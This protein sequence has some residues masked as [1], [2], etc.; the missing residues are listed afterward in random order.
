MATL[1]PLWTRAFTLHSDLDFDGRIAIAKDD[2]SHTIAPH[3]LIRGLTW[4]NETVLSVWPGGIP[5]TTSNDSQQQWDMPNAWPPLQWIAMEAFGTVSA[6]V[7]HSNTSSM[8]LWVESSASLVKKWIQTSYCGWKRYHP[9]SSL[10]ISVLNRRNGQWP[11]AVASTPDPETYRQYHLRHAYRRL[12]RSLNASES[13]GLSFTN[14]SVQG[15]MFE[16]YDVRFLGYPG[17]GGEYVVQGKL[18]QKENCSGCVHNLFLSSQT[19]NLP[20]DTSFI[21]VRWFRLDQWRDL[22]FFGSFCW[23]P[24]TKNRSSAFVQ[25]S[26]HIFCR[27]LKFVLE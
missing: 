9:T 19:L 18:K 5:T 10:D 3:D 1:Y 21:I 2:Q 26:K 11:F 15:G 24:I 14:D 13:I 25:R 6:I 4:L 7:R 16:K 17:D 22:G 27:W 8:S 12:K 23:H 20:I